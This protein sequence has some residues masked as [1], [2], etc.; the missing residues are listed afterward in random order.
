MA[1]RQSRGPGVDQHAVAVAV[2][3]ALKLDELVPAR[4]PTGQTQGGH[5]GLGAGVHHAHHLQ[6]GHHLYHQL[7]D[8]H[9]TGGGGAEA[10]AVHH[11]LFH[12]LPDDGMVVAQNHGAPGTHVV[13]VAAALHVIDVAALGPLNEPGGEPHGAVGTHGAVDAAGEHLAGGG[14]ELVR[15]VEIHPMS[16]RFMASASSLAE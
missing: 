11:G 2:V 15:I 10:Q 1:S 16:P 9:L 3:A 14:K 6:P 13:N 5:D 12:R 8:L 7:G 4:G